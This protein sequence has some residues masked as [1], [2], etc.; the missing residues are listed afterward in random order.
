MIMSNHV[1]C[2]VSS[3]T[4]K[5]SDTVR[6]LKRHTATMILEIINEETESRR[7]W[8]LFQFHHAAVQHK[9]NESLQV[10]THEN[11]AVEI[12]PYVRDMGQTKMDYI[13]NNPVRAGLVQCPEHYVY[14]SA[15]DYCGRKGMIRLDMW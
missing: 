15:G 1:H 9:C 4:G 12:D 10:W 2:L 5:L 8:I 6:D 11:H 13:H 14:S 7:E 3:K